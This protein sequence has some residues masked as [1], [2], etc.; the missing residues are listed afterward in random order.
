M[1]QLVEKF[2]QGEE[3]GKS[4]DHVG[5]S[6]SGSTITSPKSGIF[7]PTRPTLPPQFMDDKQDS[8]SIIESESK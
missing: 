1:A 5:H 8:N 4:S 2:D 3:S 6:R 7:K